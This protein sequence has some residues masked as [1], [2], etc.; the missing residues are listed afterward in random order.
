[1]AEIKELKADEHHQKEIFEGQLHEYR[2]II[3][4]KTEIIDDLEEELQR[5]SD[6]IDQLIDS[7]EEMRKNINNHNNEVDTA[8]IY[9]QEFERVKEL[10]EDEKRELNYLIYELK[11]QNNQLK[12][13]VAEE[14]RKS[15]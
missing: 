9:E 12:V 1:M 4:K 8:A 2:D 13:S 7:L 10:F 6:R 3:T 15:Q 11:E 14:E 5:R